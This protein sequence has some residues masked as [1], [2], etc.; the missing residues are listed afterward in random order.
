MQKPV[1]MPI[2]GMRILRAETAVR[3]YWSRGGQRENM[4]QIHLHAT[5]CLGD[6]ENALRAAACAEDG[7]KWSRRAGSNR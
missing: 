1:A 6:E 3:V 2:G 7:A 5:D 4:E